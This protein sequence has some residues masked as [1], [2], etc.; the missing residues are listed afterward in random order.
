MS[1]AHKPYSSDEDITLT[2]VAKETWGR[3]SAN[4]RIVFDVLFR[5]AGAPKGPSGFKGAGDVPGVSLID[6]QRVNGLKNP[7][8]PQEGQ[9][10]VPTFVSRNLGMDP[11]DEAGMREDIETPGETMG[12][13][14]AKARLLREDRRRMAV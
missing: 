9:G 6:W 1:E 3:L 10:I 14:I 8:L 4:A 13:S 7:N 11:Y 5:N 12:F 2:G